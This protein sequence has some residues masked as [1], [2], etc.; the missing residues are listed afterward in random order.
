MHS[1]S[2]DQ[3]HAWRLAQHNI[4]DRA[5]RSKMLDVLGQIG[6]AHAQVMSSGELQLGARVDDLSPADVQQALWKDRSLVKTWALRGTLHLVRVE[7]F[8]NV[9]ATLDTYVAPWY[10]SAPW[11][12]YHGITQAEQDAI[13]DAIRDTLTDTPMTR[14]QLA[15]GIAQRTGSNH[16]RDLL[17]SGWGSL[18]KPAAMRGDLCFGPSQGQNVT[19]VRPSNWIGKWKPADPARA[20]QEMARRFWSEPH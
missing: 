18:L 16:L 6:Y 12:K 10:R 17:L 5:D 8:P 9:I 2:W 1:L 14:E 15:D 7:D 13:N 3:V 20:S 19:F 11:L 4:L